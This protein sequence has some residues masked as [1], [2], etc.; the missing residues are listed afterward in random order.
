M[1]RVLIFEPQEADAR[2]AMLACARA[3]L[4]SHVAASAAQAFEQLATQRYD[5]LLLAA[6]P[7]PEPALGLLAVLRASAL[8]TAL[9]VV[10]LGGAPEPTLGRFEA[11]GVSGRLA[12][13]YAASELRTALAQAIEGSAA[14]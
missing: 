5:A 2:I 1:D 14:P 13:P 9:P 3:G 4:T 11:L 6:E 7:D 8:Y 12:K 10:A